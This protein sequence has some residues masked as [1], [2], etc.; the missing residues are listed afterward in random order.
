MQ[1]AL[2]LFCAAC[3]AALVTKGP[4]IVNA[5]SEARVRL[6]CVNWYG[7]H[8]E[9]FVVGGLEM[10]G[11]RDLVDSIVRIGANCVRIPISI[12][13]TKYN[14]VVKPH[15][16][17]GIRPGECNSTTNAMDVM[18]C[19]VYFLKSRNLMLI[20][21]S[22]TSWAGWVGGGA[23]EKQGLWN[24]PGYSTEDWIQSM[25]HIVNRYKI[26]GMDLRNEIHDMEN[27]RIT[28]G[29]STNINTDW[30]AASSLACNRLHKI[31]PSILIIVGGLCWNLDLR[32]LMRHI[33]PIQAFA[34]RKLV[35][36]AHIYTWS[37]WWNLNPETLEFVHALAALFI[38][39]CFI[40][41]VLFLC[42]FVSVSGG[43]DK[44]WV[45]YEQLDGCRYTVTCKD[46]SNVLVFASSCIWFIGWLALALLFR[47]LSL[48]GGCSSLANDAYWLVV[49]CSV[50]IGVTGL[51]I[52]CFCTELPIS[53]FLS[54]I[55]FWLGSFFVSLFVVTLYLKSDNAYTD[56]LGLWSLKQRPVPVF[57][58]EFG[59]SAG[60]SENRV[61]KLI[62]NYVI[63]KNDLDFAYWAFNGRKW[64]QQ[65]G[66]VNESFGLVAEDYK[67]IRDPLLIQQIFA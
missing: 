34:R 47:N 32:S 26:E 13:L 54:I 51:L 58:G 6:R 49:L 40:F 14:P 10:R 59:V 3:E 64:T 1:W 2:L 29:E 45:A 63:K 27:V 52:L 19:V 37:F 67:T 53:A 31:D 25:E 43:C 8:Q 9:L 56:F 21:N 4:I 61:W 66:W 35:Y 28:W 41:C 23:V 18:D 7:A 12:D 20:F 36:T 46:V 5:S 50:M 39:I 24:M 42:V 15:A 48:N 60:E 57:V 55:F 65:N 33:G 38:P 16:V 11:V 22:H 30:L 44:S 17:S 62:L